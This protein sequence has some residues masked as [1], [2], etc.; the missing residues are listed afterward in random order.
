[1]NKQTTVFVGLSGGVDSA[2]TAWR[3]KQA[4][5]L[6]V[7]VFIKVW[8]PDFLV[9]SWRRERLDAM[10]VAAHLE[11]PFL[12]CDAE[13]AYKTAVADYFISEYQKGHTPNPDV[14]CNRQIKFGAFLDFATKLGADYI[15]TGHYARL[16]PGTDGELQLHRGIDTKKDQSYFLWSL[17]RTQRSKVLFPLGDAD[18]DTVRQEAKA[19]GLPVAEK[20]DSQGI[21][22]LG[23]VDVPSFLANFITLKEGVVLD[24]TGQTIGHHQGALVY[25]IGQRHGFTITT[26]GQEIKPHY[27]THKDLV[28]NTITVSEI[29]P[30]VVATDKLKLSLR[31]TNWIEKPEVN[32]TYEAQHRYRQTPFS[33]CLNEIKEITASVTVV[34]PTALPAV[35]QSLVV[36][37]RT[38]CLGG[39]IIKACL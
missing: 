30:Q 26:K 19:V 7:G 2:V 23:Q 17:N 18:K 27:V 31:D 21:C 28:A 25:T 36:Y 14:M 22:F 6:V 11:I 37:T 3:L 8:Q 12:T 9:C 4:G 38:K 13:T 35:G 15:S 5:Y 32:A 16:K 39:G 1:M 34:G 24:E 29:P 33:V 20:K 10:R